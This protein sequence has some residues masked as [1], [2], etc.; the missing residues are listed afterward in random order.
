MRLQSILTPFALAVSITTATAAQQA[1]AVRPLGAA[2]ALST[3]PFTMIAGVREVPGGGVLVND[4]A[5]RR[6]LLL[7]QTLKTFTVVADS[8]SATA[9][10]Y[11]GRAGGLI[12]YR[13][14]STLFVDAQSSSMLVIDPRG[15][16]TRTASVP[17]SGDVM[18]LI[19]PAAASV[20]FDASGRMVYRST[21]RPPMPVI[22]PGGAFT[23]P[24][25]PDSAMIVRVDMATRK[26][27]TLAYFKIPKTTMNVTTLPNGGM[28]MTSEINPLPTTDDWAI[29]SNGTVVIVRGRDYHVDVL[30]SNG[31]MTPAPKIAYDWQRLTD[32]DKI[33]VIDSAKTAM[34]KARA[35]GTAGGPMGGA[36]QRIVAGG[37]RV[38]V[39]GGGTQVMTFIGGRGD[40]AGPGGGGPMMGAGQL[41]FVSPSALP[42]Y[43]PVFGTGALRADNDGNLWVRTSKPSNGGPIYDIIN[44]RGE[45]VDRVQIPASR[46]IV[47][48]GPGGTVYMSVREA[49]GLLLEKAKVR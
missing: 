41:N 43:R 22:M 37:D 45:L 49:S 30:G 19:G 21:V 9:N 23:P 29:L 18:S 17:R 14:D 10:A 40:G 38:A 1:P 42:D 28:S 32:E 2:V 8:T 3:E 36:E 16:I 34:E 26:L 44:A 27:D 7:D 47:G 15:K 20:G 33:A 35:A 4:M 31:E 39:G 48:F 11:G 6:V 12:A 5:K 13:G 46:T 24:A 25:F